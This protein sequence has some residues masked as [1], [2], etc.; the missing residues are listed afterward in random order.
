MDSLE[1]RAIM[2]VLP[3]IMADLDPRFIMD[4]L[5]E[6]GLI[7]PADV[8]KLT[9]SSIEL[10]PSNPSTHHHYQDEM[11][12]KINT[13]VDILLTKQDGS[14]TKFI[15]ILKRDYEWLSDELRHQYDEEIKTGD[16]L[17]KYSGSKSPFSSPIR[18][19]YRNQTSVTSEYQSTLENSSSSSESRSSLEKKF[20]LRTNS[21]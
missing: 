3:Q 13:L 21:I 5:L 6:C 2:R 10:D 1:K 17:R 15:T 18:P 7:A 14:L 11:A 9:P 20:Y 19:T 4:D 16:R 8:E 12:E